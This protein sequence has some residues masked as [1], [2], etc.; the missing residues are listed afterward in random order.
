MRWIS[1]QFMTGLSEMGYNTQWIPN[2]D[3][4]IVGSF[5]CMSGHKYLLGY[6]SL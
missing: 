2:R 1:T 5:V 6:F 3:A 4:A